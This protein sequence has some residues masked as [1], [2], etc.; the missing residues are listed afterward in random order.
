M[1]DKQ[2]CKQ[3]WNDKSKDNPLF[4]IWSNDDSKSESK[5]FSTGLD[6]YN[7]IT[8]DIKIEKNMD[9]LEIGCGVGRITFQFAKYCNLVN[10]VDICD[11]YIKLAKEYK[12]KFKISNIDFYDN[13]GE[14]FDMFADNQFDLIY[15]FIVFQH[16]PYEQILINNIKNAY[17]IIKP[18]GIFKFHHNRLE[19][20]SEGD[21]AFGC[22]LSKESIDDL[23]K[24]G[25][26]LVNTYPDENYDQYKRGW[27]TILKKI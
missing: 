17:R 2:Y 26:T 13:D 21:V 27:W 8:K 18:N 7:L 19:S 25:Y 4:W 10:G 15:S 3:W 23:V 12:D 5:F 22:S 20:Q 1:I 11:G 16:I 14:S 9:V 6:S 24:F